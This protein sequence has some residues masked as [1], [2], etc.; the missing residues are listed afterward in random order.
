M[1]RRIKRGRATTLTRGNSTLAGFVDDREAL[2]PDEFGVLVVVDDNRGGCVVDKVGPLD[3]VDDVRGLE[4]LDHTRTG[5]VAETH[6][7]DVTEHEPRGRL[8]LQHDGL[9]LHVFRYHGRSLSDYDAPGGGH[10]LHHN[11][12]PQTSA[13]DVTAHLT[14]D[15]IAHSTD[16]VTRGAAARDD[17]VGVWAW[18]EVR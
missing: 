16:D 7:A 5:L 13:H 1:T 12:T 4:V 3:S 15:V 10:S 6:R 14:D 8:L 11:A 18:L 2:I 9:P 17:R